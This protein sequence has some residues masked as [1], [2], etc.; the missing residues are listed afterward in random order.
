[1]LKAGIMVEEIKA[2]SAKMEHSLQLAVY[3]TVSRELGDERWVKENLE[4]RIHSF[5]GYEQKQVLRILLGIGSI[6]ALA[7]VVEHSE[8]LDD[9]REYNFSFSDVNAATLLVQVL[10]ICHRNKYN[11]DYTNTSIITSLERIAISDE[12]SLNQV[13]RVI[14]EL[15]SRDGYYKY[16]NR[17]LIQFENKYFENHSPV[18]SIDEVLNMINRK[19]VEIS[20]ESKGCD[21]MPVYIS[22][23]WEYSSDAIV[24]HFCLVLEQNGIAYKRDKKDCNYMDNIRDFMDSIRNGDLIVVVFSRKYMLSKNCMYEL[25]GIMQHENWTNKILPVVVD[26][27]IRERSF[28]KE[29]VKHWK[30]EKDELEEEVEE[31]KE[32]GK[33]IVAPIEDEL[34]EVSTIFGFLGELKRYVD[35]VNADSLHNLSSTNF[36]ALIDKIKR[37][38]C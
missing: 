21:V 14:K 29:L 33:E 12:E 32:Y 23:S 26:D 37:Q 16:M 4:S 8:L 36:K 25:S 38:K 15:I 7:F 1:M 3:A 24:N 22:Y 17:Y 5:E 20:D 6:D 31:M 18:K 19:D 28:Y 2:A 13:K 27:S 35:W 34:K 11:N 9:Y 30:K 10:D